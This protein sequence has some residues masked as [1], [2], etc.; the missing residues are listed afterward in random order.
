MVRQNP[1]TVTKKGRG[2][3]NCIET[4]ELVG[5]LVKLTL[6]GEHFFVRVENWSI[7]IS[8]KLVSG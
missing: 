3:N 8:R 4:A 2:D 7:P 1:K 6:N 5:E